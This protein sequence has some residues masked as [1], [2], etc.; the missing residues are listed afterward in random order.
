VTASLIEH[1]ASLEDP[2]IDR[3]KYHALIDIVVLTVCAV[4]SGADGWEELNSSVKKN[5]I[6]CAS[7][8]PFTMACHRTIVSLMF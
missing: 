7:T 1:F 6:G 5:S 8:Y 2:R 3:N 4:A